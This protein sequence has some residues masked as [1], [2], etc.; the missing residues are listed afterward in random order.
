MTKTLFINGRFLG[1]PI[2]GVERFAREV[3]WAMD[4]LLAQDKTAPETVILAPS[5]TPA[6]E[7]LQKIKFKTCGTLSG[8][9]WEQWDLWRAARG[10]INLTQAQQDIAQVYS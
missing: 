1:K 2:T 3:V 10:G 5:G 8:H 9:A 7:N 4:S 6:P